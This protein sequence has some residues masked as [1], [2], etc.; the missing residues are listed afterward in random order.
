VVV[1]PRTGKIITIINVFERGGNLPQD[2][3][4]H[5]LFRLSQF[6][7]IKLQLNDLKVNEILPKCKYRIQSEPGKRGKGANFKVRENLEKSGS[8]FENLHRSGEKVREN[9]L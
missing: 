5:F 4:P 7:E 8:F 1:A 6:S 3:I 9:I 2:D